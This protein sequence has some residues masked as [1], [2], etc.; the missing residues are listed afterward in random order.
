MIRIVLDT[1]VLIS[2]M[3]NAFGAPGRIVDLI[4]E[5][6]VEIA[7]D[8]RILAEYAQVIRR[9]KFE[10]YF[11]AS[12]VRDILVFLGNHAYYVVS[13]VQAI[14]LP[15]P[16]DAPFLEVAITAGVPLVTGNARD[17]PARCRRNTTVYTPADFLRW[18]AGTHD[19]GEGLG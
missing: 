16:N 9:P 14:D 19:K 7:V 6:L 15:D 17:F 18:Y 11:R 3:I 8:D 12:E 4:R 5:G 13:Q 1:N 10:M 2:G